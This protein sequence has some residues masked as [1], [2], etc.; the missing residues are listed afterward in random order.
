MFIK[1]IKAEASEVRNVLTMQD[2]ELGAIESW[3]WWD[4]KQCIGLVVHRCGD[5]LVLVGGSRGKCWPDM[6]RLMNHK[7]YK[8]CSVRVFKPRGKVSLEA[9]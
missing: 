2:G 3:S 9:L 1:L 6:F 7:G 8:D 5:D 4:G